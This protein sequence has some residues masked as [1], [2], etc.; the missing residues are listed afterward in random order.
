MNNMS[1]AVIIA[2]ALLA[3]TIFVDGERDRNFRRELIRQCVEALYDP[4]AADE[5]GA[6]YHCIQTLEG[7]ERT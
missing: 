4:A 2:A 5:A 3:G 7:G 1:L 6:R